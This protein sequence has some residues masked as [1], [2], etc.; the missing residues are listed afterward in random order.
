MLDASAGLPIRPLLPVP[1][2]AGPVQMTAYSAYG[3]ALHSEIPLRGLERAP[4]GKTGSVTVSIQL[5][6]LPDAVL[7]ERP[8]GPQWIYGTYLDKATV[9]VADGERIVLDVLEPVEESAL[10]ALVL[11]ELMATLLRQRGLLVLHACT[12]AGA[13]G[14]LCFAGESGWGKSTLAEAFCQAG[15]RLVTDDVTAIL[16]E[17]GQACAVPSYPQ[18]RLREDAAEYL[19][20][21]GGLASI[22]RNGPKRA[23]V[24]HPMER[25]PVPLRAVLLLEPAY[26]DRAEL[27]EVGRQEALMR[28]VAHTRAQTLVNSNVPALLADHL[29]QCSGLLETVP[30]RLLTRRRSLD[31][32]REVQELVEQ[33]FNLVPASA[34]AGMGGAIAG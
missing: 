5:R 18:I 31:G 7:E 33:A 34:T 32:L 11:G 6:P 17:G 23:S 8:V 4:A 10:A 21:G 13:S 30:V 1:S 20:P 27:K 24:A 15:Y 25:G 3:L 22:D 29:A 2:N 26:R 14:A 12:V 9:L 19:V 28:L 16:V